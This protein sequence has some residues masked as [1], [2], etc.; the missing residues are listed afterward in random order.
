MN[1]FYVIRFSRLKRWTL[2][3]VLAF[4]TAGFLWFEN[5]GSLSI[6]SSDKPVALTK[7]NSNEPNISL[8]FNISWGEEKVYDILKQLENHQVKATFFVSGEWAEKHPDIL[9]KITEGK[10]EI[11]MLGYRYK[12][13]LDQEINQVRKD[14]QY[15]KAV[16]GKLGYNNME[17]VRA[18]HG[19]FNDEVIELAEGLGNKV[20]HWNVNPNDWQN[21]GTQIIVDQVMSQTKNGDII[22][23]HASDSAKQTAESLKTILPG[24]KNKGFNFVTVSELMNQAHAKSKIVD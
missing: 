17:L 4:F 13:Y 3:I 14:L 11:G 8:T 2:I 1:H 23:L 21:P 22:L 19:H 18:P 24:L 10:H 9:K 7:G 12:S 6:F 15:A 5:N 20:I 16:F